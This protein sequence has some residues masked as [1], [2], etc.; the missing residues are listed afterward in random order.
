MKSD[1]SMEAILK[2]TNAEDGLK[3]KKNFGLLEG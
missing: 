2:K 3:L 1:A